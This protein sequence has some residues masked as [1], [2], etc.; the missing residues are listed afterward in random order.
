[1][2]DLVHGPRLTAGQRIDYAPTADGRIWVYA[3][4]DPVTHEMRYI[5]QSRDPINRHRW[6]ITDAVSDTGGQEQSRAKREWI[7]ACVAAGAYPYC[8]LLEA[9]EDRD[10]A[11]SREAKWVRR[12]RSTL[13]NGGD[14]AEYLARALRSRATRAKNPRP[15]APDGYL[16]VADAAAEL[17]ISRQR[18]HQIRAAWGQRGLVSDEEMER[19][20]TR[21][22]SRGGRRR[23]H[24][25]ERIVL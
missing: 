4:C 21:P 14:E 24:H 2:A 13:T 22:S 11:L 7:R 19:L 3:L 12:H 18:L 15:Q 10:T 23:S 5:G 17:G 20:R 8:R 25:A 9:A 16:S 6:H 1:M